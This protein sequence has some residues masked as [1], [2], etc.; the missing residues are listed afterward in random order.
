MGTIKQETRTK[1]CQ[2]TELHLKT[3]TFPQPTTGLN[4]GKAWCWQFSK[5]ESLNK[6]NS[7]ITE[8][9][10][11]VFGYKAKPDTRHGKFVFNL[12]T[13]VVP[14]TP[15]SPSFSLPSFS[16]PDFSSDEESD[17]ETSQTL[18]K[19]S[20]SGLER[21]SSLPI[22]SEHKHNQLRE[23][24][25]LLFSGIELKERHCEY[26][27]LSKSTANQLVP[28]L[29]SRMRS[30]PSWNL[31]YSMDQHGSSMNTLFRNSR[32]AGPCIMAIRTSTNQVFGAYLSHSLQSS[33][34][35]YGNGECF[36]WRESDTLEVF[37]ATGLNHYFILC[38]PSYISLGGG[39][40][41]YGL[42]LD[43]TLERGVSNSCGTFNNPP[44]DEASDFFCVDLEIWEIASSNK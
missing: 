30:I 3:Y 39:D 40:G 6:R 25:S 11:Q 33:P 18:Y 35:Y 14:T 2:Q 29:P 28:F 24:P 36:L 17:Q 38:E 34:S 7:T 22:L 16:F 4:S 20:H 13:T 12:T 31:V 37:N 42:Y 8:H 44:L 15:R 41:K 5:P 26:Q 43:A 27:V 23:R 32:N 19:P 1:L 21:T 9:M 10:L